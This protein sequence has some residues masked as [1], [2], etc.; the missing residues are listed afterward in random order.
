VLARACAR[1]VHAQ[2]PVLTDGEHEL[3]RAAGAWQAEWNAL[4]E[5][6]ALAGGSAAS[7]RNCLDGLGVDADRMRANMSD[8]LYAERDALAE[9]GVLGHGADDTYLGSASVFIDRA[10][11][12]YRETQ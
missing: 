4:S 9:R 8:A 7:I 6:L 2:L 1:G 12:R 10:L 3:D 11:A 5:A